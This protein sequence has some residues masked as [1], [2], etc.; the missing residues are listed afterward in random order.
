MRLFY[1]CYGST[2]SSVVAAAIHLGRLPADRVPTLAEIIALPDFDRIPHREIGRPRLVGR[3][4]DG[5]EIYVL[6]TRGNHRLVKRAVRDFLHLALG[7][8]P[9]DLRF[10]NVLPAA[11]ILL[12]IGGFLSR[13]LGLVF[14]GRY[15]AAWGVRSSY[16]G[17]A[18]IV[19]ATR[20]Q[21]GDCG[22]LLRDRGR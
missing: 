21:L 5:R 20:E 11:G 17:L 14:P 1:H 3:D 8:Q 16:Q 6:G 12:R 9:G 15:L 19:T 13:R 10:I 7:R 2:H 18:A 22:P 4:S